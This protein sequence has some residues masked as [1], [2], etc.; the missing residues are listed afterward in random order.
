METTD[1]EPSDNPTESALA[2]WFQSTNK[3]IE[4][5]MSPEQTSLRTAPA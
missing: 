3:H 2:V 5:E 4:E 1:R